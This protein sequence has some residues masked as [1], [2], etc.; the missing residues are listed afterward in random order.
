M[1]KIKITPGTYLPAMPVVIIGAKVQEKPNFM[2]IAWCSIVENKPPMISVSVHQSHYTNQGIKDNQTFSVNIP[3]KELI[4]AT[5]YVG[6]RSGKNVDK[7]DVFEIFYGEL[8]TA[9]LIKNA[10]INLECKV[11]KTIDTLKGH[12]IFIGEIK[13]V[14]CEERYLE[15]GIPELEKIEPLIY[16]TSDKSYWS[17]GERL[18]KAWNVGKD[19]K[20]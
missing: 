11:Y 18:A 7:S 6:I 13:N 2:T 9:P 3:S 1:G 19:Y 10:A 17:V 4:E 8:E 20:K 5:D 15:D 12:D 16:S 14:F